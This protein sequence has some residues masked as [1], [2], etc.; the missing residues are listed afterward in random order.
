MRLCGW[1]PACR[2]SNGGIG[3]ARWL[4]VQGILTLQHFAQIIVAAGAPLA[5]EERLAETGAATLSRWPI[6]TLLAAAAV[7]AA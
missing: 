5:A 2:G 1:Q 6:K 3:S 4:K 7:A